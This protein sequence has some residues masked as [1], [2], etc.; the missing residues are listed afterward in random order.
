MTDYCIEE[1]EKVATATSPNSVGASLK[2]QKV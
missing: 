2:K 1:E